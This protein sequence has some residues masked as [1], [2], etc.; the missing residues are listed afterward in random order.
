MR[1]SLM[2]IQHQFVKADLWAFFRTKPLKHCE[3]LLKTSPTHF[4]RYLHD[5]RNARQSDSE[6]CN[7]ACRNQVHSTIINQYVLSFHESFTRGFTHI[8]IAVHKRDEDRV[9]KICSTLDRHPPNSIS[10]AIFDRRLLTIAAMR[11]WR[12]VLFTQ[13]VVWKLKVHLHKTSEN[14]S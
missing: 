11:C 6:T 7:G 4:S 3:W 5:A 2:N 8:I 13:S 10:A 1:W 9:G 14:D 12:S